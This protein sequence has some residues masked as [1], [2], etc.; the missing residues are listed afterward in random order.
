MITP[1]FELS[2]AGFSN[3]NRGYVEAPP[4]QR[5]TRGGILS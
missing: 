4:M 1:L 5:E 2:Q 3:E